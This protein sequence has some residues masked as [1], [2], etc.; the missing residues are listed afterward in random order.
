MPSLPVCGALRNRVL[1][2][3]NFLHIF[4]QLGSFMAE[5]E[6]FS[7]PRNCSTEMAPSYNQS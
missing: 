5:N 6:V 4:V 2:A 1:R 7:W 3:R